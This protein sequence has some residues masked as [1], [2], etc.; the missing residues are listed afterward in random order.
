MS[1]GT[2][3]NAA[4]TLSALAA[5]YLTRPLGPPGRPRPGIGPDGLEAVFDHL[6]CASVT[7]SYRLG[8][9]TGTLVSSSFAAKF[10]TVLASAG[11]PDSVKRDAFR[12]RMRTDLTHVF[13]LLHDGPL[14]AN[15]AAP[16]HASCRGQ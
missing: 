2:H 15:I 16:G 9:R 4:I 3:T 7:L 13:D 12:T 10:Y 11:K 6:G 8:N 5:I 1:E 14:R